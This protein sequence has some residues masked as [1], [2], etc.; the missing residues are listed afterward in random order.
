[1]GSDTAA[2]RP[3]APLFARRAAG[4]DCAG[5]G[6]W[7]R[8]AWAAPQHL[9]PAAQCP[10][11]GPTRPM[12]GGGPPRGPNTSRRPTEWAARADA[13]VRAGGWR[14]GAGGRDRPQW[15][16]LPAP[17]P[18]RPP[19]PAGRRYRTPHSHSLTKRSHTRRFRPPQSADPEPEP[20]G[21][22]ES[23][24]LRLLPTGPSGSL[25]RLP[26]GPSGGRVRHGPRGGGGATARRAP[27]EGSERPASAVARRC[28]ATLCI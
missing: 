21:E 6:A 17:L 9:L 8:A 3:P 28:R 12:L 10:P 13:P 1:M 26:S 14:E 4:A 7:W 19:L 25:G 2:R 18:A 27:F 5:P 23:V 20:K 16:A 22:A 24:D 11:G 15:R